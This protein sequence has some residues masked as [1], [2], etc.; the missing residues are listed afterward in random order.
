MS[1]KFSNF[2]PHCS[3]SCRCSVC[4]CFP[5]CQINLHHYLGGSSPG[6]PSLP[7]LLAMSCPH[8]PSVSAQRLPLIFTSTERSVRVS[9]NKQ[10]LIMKALPLALF[11]ACPEPFSLL[12]S[13]QVWMCNPITVCRKLSLSQ[14]RGLVLQLQLCYPRIVPAGLRAPR[15]CSARV[16]APELPGV[17]HCRCYTP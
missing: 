7:S 16:C 1:L 9:L 2:F 14:H 15:C 13:K 6:Q 5:L 12:L 17:F 8:L 10:L 4:F 11:I 3:S